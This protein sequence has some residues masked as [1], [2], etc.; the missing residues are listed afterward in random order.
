[1]ANNIS[2]DIS[3]SDG[4]GAAQEPAPRTRNTCPTAPRTTARTRWCATCACARTAA[5]TS[6]SPRASG[7][8]RSPTRA[9][10]P[11][12]RRGLDSSD[13][14]EF[15]D[16]Q[17]VPGAA[18]RGERSTGLRDAADRRR[19]AR[20]AARRRRSSVMDFSFLGGRMGSV[21]GEKFTRAADLAHRAAAC[22]SSRCRPRAAPACRRACS[23]SCRWERRSRRS[24]SCGRP[25]GPSSRCS[26]TRPRA[27]WRPASPRSATSSSPSRAR[28]S[29]SRGRGS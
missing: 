23:R 28:C 6:R 18:A 14:L 9:R 2:V 22:R 19:R 11:R 24:T 25:A 15:V 26:S 17:P 12:S 21:V 7:S 3:R 13:P 10:S 1:M 27:A 8:C 5:T 29:R 4:A 16:S 20:S